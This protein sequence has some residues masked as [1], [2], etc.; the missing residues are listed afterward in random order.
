MRREAVRLN[1][2]RL[3]ALVGA[4]KRVRLGRGRDD[5]FTLAS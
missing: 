2:L 5:E 1:S 3:E 4:I